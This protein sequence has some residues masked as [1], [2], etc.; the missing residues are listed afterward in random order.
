VGLRA[1]LNTD[2]RGKIVCICR[3]SNPGRLVYT[4][5][6][7]AELPLLHWVPDFSFDFTSG[8]RHKKKS[9]NR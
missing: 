5:T 6:I 9:E 2:A 3:G 4:D 7:L 8:T 1:G